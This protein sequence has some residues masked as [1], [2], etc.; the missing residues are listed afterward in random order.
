MDNYGKRKMKI[1]N[2]TFMVCPLVTLNFELKF[3][4]ALEDYNLAKLTQ[5]LNNSYF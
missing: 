1:W 5:Y 4:G 3:L 2:W